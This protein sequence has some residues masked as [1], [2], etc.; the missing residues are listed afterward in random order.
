MTTDDFLVG[1]KYSMKII[2][3]S[4]L[5]LPPKSLPPPTSNS[6]IAGLIEDFEC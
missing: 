1:A 6:M 3:Y 2:T 4:L 5:P